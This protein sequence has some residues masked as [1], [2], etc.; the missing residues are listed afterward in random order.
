MTPEFE[1]LLK[2]SAAITGAILGWIGVLR[3]F[4]SW[5]V[6]RKDRR[7]AAYKEQIRLDKDF[8]ETLLRKLKEIEEFQVELLDSIADLQRDAIERTYFTCVTEHGYCPSGMKIAM[9]EMYKSFKKR[10]YNYVAKERVDEV[11]RLPEFPPNKRKEENNA[12][13]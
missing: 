4:L 2:I 13:D 12:K 8:R 10:G 7:N 6:K 9:G 3:P 5:W 1:T 11:I